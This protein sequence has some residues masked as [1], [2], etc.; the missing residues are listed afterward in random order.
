MKSSFRNYLSKQYQLYLE[1]N[2]SDSDSHYVFSLVNVRSTGPRLKRGT[3]DSHFPP[4]FCD[5]YSSSQERE[6]GSCLKI[7]L[8]I[9]YYATAAFVFG[10]FPIP[11]TNWRKT[12]A[13]AALALNPAKAHAAGDTVVYNIKEATPVERETPVNSQVQ[14]PKHREK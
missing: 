3:H 14:K 10:I 6:D 5:W 8:L 4:R 1:L 9:T 12:K 11:W 13:C 2:T 7:G